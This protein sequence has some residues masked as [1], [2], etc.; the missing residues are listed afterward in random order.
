MT[1]NQPFAPRGGKAE[2]EEGSGFSPKFDADGL[3]PAMAIDAI[4]KEPLMLAYMNEESLRLT[5]EVGDHRGRKVRLLGLA[6]IS[7]HIEVAVRAD[8]RAVRPVDVNRERGR[9]IQTEPPSGARRPGRG[10]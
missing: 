2:I 8:A 7:H 6:T 3:I 9:A 10:G 4:T 1:S 5:L